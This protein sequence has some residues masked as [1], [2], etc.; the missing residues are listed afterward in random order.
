[1]GQ[2]Q[3]L[4]DFRHVDFYFTQSPQLFQN[5]WATARTQTVRIAMVGDSQETSPTSH[6]FQYIPRVNYEMWQ[7]FGNV[8]ETPIEGCFYY[9]DKPP[10]DWLMA[11][12]CVT[13]GPVA[14]RLNASQILPNIVPKAFSTLNSATN[15][16]HGSHG[17]LSL[18]EPNAASVDPSAAIPTNTNYFNTSGSV[19]AQIFAATN[20]SSGEVSYIAR[21]TSN[22]F[23]SYSAAPTTTGTL[24][25]GLQ[26]SAFAVKSGITAALNFNGK[27]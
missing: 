10:G 7:R 9:V 23:P 18:L 6:G 21:P 11:G 4:Q 17:Q 5:L 24:T 20:A 3:A 1:M 8:P 12:S 26:S 15:I 13:P 22:P 14:T 19:K 2:Q 16:T 27:R 25:L